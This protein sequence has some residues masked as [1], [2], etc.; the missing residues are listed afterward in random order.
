M[1][2]SSMRTSVAGWI[3]LCV[4]TI[5]WVSQCLAAEA[6]K[7]PAGPLRV[8]PVNPRYFTDGTK[9]LDGSLKAVYLTGSH[10]WGNLADSHEYPEFNFTSYLDFLGKYHH[11]FIRLWSGYNLGREPIPYERSG[12]TAALD[13]QPKVDLTRFDL[14]F[15]ER[16]RSRVIAA[17]DR[18]IYVGIMLFRPDGAKKEKWP[19]LLFNP[20]NNAQAINADTNGDGSGAEAYDL[21][22]PEITALEEAFVR[23][24]IDSVHDLDNVLFEIGNEGD[25]TSVRWQHHFIRFIKDYERGKQ[26][27]HPVGMTSVFNILN[28]SWATEDRALWDSPADWISP[29]ASSY[30]GDPPAAVGT[31][32][33]IADVDHI[34]PA[35]PHAGWIWRCFLRGIQPI[36]MDQYS[37]GDPKWT[38]R[39]E[40]EAMRRNMGYALTYA[41]K[42]DLAA[43]TPRSELASTKYC[44]AHPGTEYLVY[45]PTAGEAFSVELKAATYRYEWFDP[46][47]GAA[48]RSGSI[49]ATGKVQPFRAPFEGDAILYLQAQSK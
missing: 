3:R 39:A 20:A 7:L 42:I 37:Y 5:L 27:Q 17:R 45:Q 19:R 34:W 22:L 14:R 31:K 21:S 12:S 38:S 35:A 4:A 30:K 41:N 44:L 43:V 24:V 11:N 36:L 23:K 47:N 9:N 25:W 28:G 18:G 48:A 33:I 32:V 13:G 2:M 1:N 8:H 40:Q 29:G 16:L 49:E 46:A 6:P 26:K 10:T 15:F